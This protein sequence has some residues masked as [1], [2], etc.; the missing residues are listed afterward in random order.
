MR[1]R[2]KSLFLRS[3]REV[4]GLA[5][6]VSWLREEVAS[7]QTKERE[8]HQHADETEDKLKAMIAKVGEDAVELGR[9][10]P[11][12]D[13]ARR[14]LENEQKSKKEVEGLATALVEDVGV[15]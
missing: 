2:E 5:A 8:A 11:S 10:C 3:E 13:L 9:L 6:E 4:C 14:A 1:S 15:L 12:L 7:L